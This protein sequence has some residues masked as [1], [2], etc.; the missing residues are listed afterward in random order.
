M[1]CVFAAIFQVTSAAQANDYPKSSIRIINASSAGGVS[2]VFIRSIVD[3]LGERLKQPVVVENRPGGAF[4]IATRACA[5][6]PPDGYTFCVLPGE[7]FIFNP[8]LFKSLP[9]D[10]DKAADPIMVLF[11]MPQVL[12]VGAGLGVKSV[13]ELVAVSKAKPNTMSYSSPGVAQAAFVESFVKKQKGGDLV[14]VPFKGGGDA[15]NGIMTG[16]TPV[17]FIGVGNLLGHFQAKTVVGLAID[18]EERLPLIPDVPSIREVGF[19]GDMVQ[20]FYALFAPPGTP[21]PIVDLI[22]AEVA[23]IIS[24]PEF[25]QKNV[26]AR[27]LT[28]TA[29]TA[30]ELRGMIKKGRSVAGRVVEASGL[31]PQ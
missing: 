11:S 23:R 25:L 20:P 6:S 4:N 2:D 24:R 7:V 29:G 21:K 16:A 31:T 1:A 10:P 27:G 17:A 12:A 8:T 13:D 28:L 26:S 19:T 5:E 15:V 3:E 14:K 18:S 22:R 30:D 9:F